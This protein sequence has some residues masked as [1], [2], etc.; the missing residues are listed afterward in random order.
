MPITP[1]LTKYLEAA[2]Q[3]GIKTGFTRILP[4]S[5]DILLENL[6]DPTNILNIMT[7]PFKS[8]LTE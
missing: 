8:K 7:N 3:K 1:A 6:A 4:Y 2:A 5:Y